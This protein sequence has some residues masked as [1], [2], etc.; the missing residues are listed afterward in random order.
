MY[1]QIKQLLELLPLEC[2]IRE[3]LGKLPDSL[4][5][6]YDEIYAKI[7]ARKGIAPEIAN[8]AFQWVMCSCTP[9]SPGELVVAVRQDPETDATVSVDINMSIVLDACHNL[10]V[11]DQQ[12]GVC[13]FSHLSVQE[14]FENH[15]WNQSQANGLVAKVCL[16]LLNNPIQQILEPR[17]ANEQDRN[18][19]IRDIVQYARLHWA[20]HVQ[21]HGEERIDDRLAMLLRRFLGSMNESGLAYRSWHWMITK[22]FVGQIWGHSNIP[23]NG[24]YEQLIPSSLASFSICAFGFHKVLSDWWASGFVNVDQKNHEGESLLGLA[25][26]GGFASVTEELLTKNANVNAQSRV[27]GNVLQAASAWGHDQIVQ[28]LLE[29]GADVNAQGGHYGNALQAASAGG[30]DQ[31]VQRLLRGQSRASHRGIL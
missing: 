30:H 5:K 14:Y 26:V 4:D 7:R 13:R 22:F 3:R 16:S 6:A 31:I 27:Y 24:I 8:R 1:L 12:L 21:R 23:L 18:D 20:T 28:Q 9:L 15:H 19:G 10:L 2:D 11:V 25:V 17:P 29:K